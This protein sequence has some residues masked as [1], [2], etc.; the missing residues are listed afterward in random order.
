MPTDAFGDPGQ[1]H[2][3]VPGLLASALGDQY[4]VRRL[5]GRGGFAEV[6]E[7][8][9]RT[10]DRR[11]AIKVLR[12]DIAWTAGMLARFRQEARAVARLTHS[13]ILPI[14]F[15]GEG[16]GLVYYAMP[17]VEG[18][19]LGDL[20]R[21]EGALD[22]TRALAMVRP[23]LEALGH[24]HGQ[25]FLH[26]D[27]KPDNVMIE[28]GSDRVL[29]MDFGIA[30]QVDTKAAL[31]QTGFV[32]GTPHYM[33]P[34]QA[35]GQTELDGRSD[36][37]SVGAM[38][39]QMV[40]GS[41]PFEADTSQEVVAKHISEPP[42]VPARL[43]AH[44]PRVL[45]DVIVRCLAKRPSDRFSSAAA[46]VEALD[47][48]RTSGLPEAVSAEEVARQFQAQETTPIATPSAS[49][50]VVDEIVPPPKRRMGL[51]IA[52]LAL[53]VL[54]GGA[55]AFFALRQPSLLVENG[56]V[57]P[58]QVTVRDATHEVEAASQ[59]RV[60]LARGGTL[61]AQWSLQ[62]P[63]TPSGRAMG[64]A[65]EGAFTADRPR[66]TVKR[67][68]DSRPGGRPY[69]APLITN[70]TDEVL[71]VT[72]N[73]GLVAVLSCGCRIP[74]GMSRAVVGYYPL[75]S[76]SSVEVRD[77]RGRSAIFRDVATGVDAVSGV[78]EI[79]VEESDL[80]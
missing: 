27:I 64:V 60:A 61:M 39:F 74:V 40:T 78:V 57:S 19:S 66:G 4:D 25:G 24:A 10:L 80:R 21:Q 65:V 29:L 9:D 5:V 75:F 31:T 41:P 44:I 76:N 15:V 37:Y 48:G 30:K 47:A 35:L 45:S 34:E 38:L 18:R 72:V 14:H 69:F 58:I 71:S 63:T 52:V 59:R 79:Y 23:V 51:A 56:L 54:G 28:E 62:Q 50:T 46:V 8:W 17:F 3:D 77:D 11:L 43:N 32:V 22:P 33:S 53:V 13:N 1:P 42:P 73:P 49:G 2:L 36:L 68:A 16:G 7:V 12:P 70:A 6:Y 26:R 67:M 20:I 55:V